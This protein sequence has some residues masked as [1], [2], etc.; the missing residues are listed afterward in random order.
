[1]EELTNGRNFDL[2]GAQMD[3]SLPTKLDEL[4]P[5][6]LPG[7]VI[8]C[9][10]GT[11]AMLEALVGRYP[12]S[13]FLGI[14]LSS[15]FVRRAQNRFRENPQVRILRADARFLEKVGGAD[16]STVIL[17]SVLHEVHSY[18]GYDETPVHEVLA[19]AYQAL[20]QGGRVVIRDGLAPSRAVV[21]LRCNSEDGDSSGPIEKLSTQA[22]FERFLREYRHGVGVPVDEAYIGGWHCYILRARDAYEFLVKKDYRNH[23]DLEVHEEYGFWRRRE[24]EVGLERAGFKNIVIRE[25]TNQWMVENRFRGSVI[26]F[27]PAIGMEFPLPFFP[28]H[29]VIAAE[30]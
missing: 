10:F 6:I 1:M 16:A 13:R 28:T 24:W 9:G 22:V 3:A 4:L 19:A 14:D 25:V 12:E 17:S 5:H 21:A 30:K 15:E 27:N 29:V 11:G 20:R 2:Y 23:W 26:L 8:D 18:N 7:F